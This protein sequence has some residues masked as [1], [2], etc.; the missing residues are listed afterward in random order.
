[1][2]TIR[3]ADVC[4]FGDVIG[5]LRQEPSGF[6]FA[7]LP[8]YQGIPLSLSLPIEQREFYS[9]NLFPYFIG[10]VPEGWLKEK[11]AEVQKIDPCDLF[12]L[13]LNNG[14]NLIGAV[15]VLRR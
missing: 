11:Y 15:Q 14:K 1:M 10:L 4:L 8:H 6:Y 3:K 12:G 2:H 5:E 7:Y 9:E 13:L